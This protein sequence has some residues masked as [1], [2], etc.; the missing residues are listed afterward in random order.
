MCLDAKAMRSYAAA[1]GWETRRRQDRASPIEEGGTNYMP[2]GGG[3]KER[4]AGR[5]S[6]A[7][8]PLLPETKNTSGGETVRVALDA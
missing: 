4:R 8:V 3:S 1:K 7:N 2:A 5:M 6:A